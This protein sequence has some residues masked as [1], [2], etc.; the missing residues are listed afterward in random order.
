MYPHELMIG[1][2]LMHYNGTTMQV[3][4]IEGCHFACGS[5]HCWEY[6]NVFKPIPITVEILEKNGWT[7]CNVDDDGSVQYEYEEGNVDVDW[8]SPSINIPGLF[9]CS[10]RD[11]NTGIIHEMINELPISY[12]HE[13]QN[14]LRICGI[15]KEIVL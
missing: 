1:N 9:G 14:I 2:W 8:W 12:V 6:N 11:E 5:P 7:Q 3:T 4:R 13:L 15:K 10:T